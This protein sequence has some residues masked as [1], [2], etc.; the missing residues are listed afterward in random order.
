MGDYW[1]WLDEEYGLSSGTS[2]SHSCSEQVKKYGECRSCAENRKESEENMRLLR[3]KKAKCLYKEPP[4]KCPYKFEHM[5]LKQ[6][7]V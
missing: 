4:K 7:L 2:R 6:E 3:I 5:I 1:C